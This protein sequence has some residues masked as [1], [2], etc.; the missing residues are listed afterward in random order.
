VGSEHGEGPPDAVMQR[1]AESA[2]RVVTQG[3]QAT[4]R[5]ASRGDV[6]EAKDP[7]EGRDVLGHGR[8]VGLPLLGCLSKRL[9]GFIKG[10]LELC[11]QPKRKTSNT[12]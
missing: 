1:L 12:S 9:G 7:S 8:V 6:V 10:R 4:L 5:G 11:E 3:L 2:P